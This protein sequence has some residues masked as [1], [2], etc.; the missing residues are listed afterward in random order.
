MVVAAIAANVRAAVGS[1][2]VIMGTGL[3]GLGAFSHHFEGLVELGP[4]GFKATLVGRVKRSARDLGLPAAEAEA[5]VE[6]IEKTVKALEPRRGLVEVFPD[7]RRQSKARPGGRGGEPRAAGGVP[8]R[9]QVTAGS[10]ACRAGC[11][12][13][14]P[15]GSWRPYG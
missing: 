10:S 12:Y 4:Q 6:R 7:R 8:C 5:A 15:V 9:S 2:L 1:T 14:S 13:P 3:L 11:C